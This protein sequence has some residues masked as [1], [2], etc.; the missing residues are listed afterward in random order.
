ME[1]GNPGRGEGAVEE[2]VKVQAKRNPLYLRLLM[3]RRLLIQNQSLAVSKL[4][5]SDEDHMG[6]QMEVKAR[7][8]RLL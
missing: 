3:P 6:K 2:G 4:G 8:H 1:V 7:S 5:T